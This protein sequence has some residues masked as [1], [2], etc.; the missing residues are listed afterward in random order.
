M[1]TF[2]L[3]DMSV[4][5]GVCG[6]PVRRSMLF[7]SVDVIE[8][9]R[10]F[11]QPEDPAKYSRLRM[12]TPPT[13]EYTVKAWQGVTHKTVSPTW[14]RFKGRLEGDPRKYGGLQPTEEVYKS[15]RHS[16]DIAKAVEAKVLLLQLPPSLKWEDYMVETLSKFADES[17]IQ[18]AIEPREDSWFTKKVQRFLGEMGY[19]FVTDPFD[20]GIVDIHDSIIYLRLHG[21]G[22]YRYD[23]S[24][25]DM[26]RLYHMIEKYI[27]NKTVYVLFNNVN[28][29][30]DAVEFRRLVT[31]L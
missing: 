25:R 9:Q 3:L 21:I 23:Y 2:L 26:A 16:L 12:E 4:K 14:R 27:D 6:F 19:V 8:I 13:V 1:D 5:V 22:G 11:Y 29:F 15:F 7:E 24:D 17:E 20:R 10:T 31:T 28:M 30:R 18:L